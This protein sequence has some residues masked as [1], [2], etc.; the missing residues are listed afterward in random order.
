MKN[1]LRNFIFVTALILSFHSQAKVVNDEQLW[2]NINA[3]F[4]LNDKWQL[5]TE[6]QPRYM[7]NRKYLSLYFLR[8]MIVR[9][10]DHGFSTGL[11]YAFVE[12]DNFPN[13]RYIHEDRFWLQLGHTYD[14]DKLNIN[15]R[16]RFEQRNFRHDNM[17]GYRLRHMVKLTYSLSDTWKAIA[18]DEWFWN[19]NDLSPK[20]RAHQGSIAEGFD[21]NRTFLG[22]GYAFGENKQ[23][24]VEVGY[25]YQYINGI[26]FDRGNNIASVTAILKF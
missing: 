6:Y 22:A 8:G 16:T 18:W 2:V 19:A 24:I 10:L 3:W 7:D 12:F 17:P 26:A 21:Q 13:P 14:W 20:V 9:K 25:M 23:H 5:Y 4:K 15:N 11:G 1:A